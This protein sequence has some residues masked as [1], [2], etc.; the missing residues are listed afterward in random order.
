[1]VVN[2]ALGSHT[3]STITRTAPAATLAADLGRG[4]V[5]PLGIAAGHPHGG[6]VQIVP[7]DAEFA[8]DQFRV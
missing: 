7:D 1:M 8:F 4:D 6:A 3:P 5:D 2:A